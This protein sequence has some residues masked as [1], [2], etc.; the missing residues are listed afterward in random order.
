MIYTLILNSYLTV[1][2]N[3][4]QCFIF[5]LLFPVR[6]NTQ[7]GGKCNRAESAL[8]IMLPDVSSQM[9]TKPTA[10]PL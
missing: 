7:S 5:Q 1:V 9:S 4:I 10:A 8:K 2:F 3:G 6:Q